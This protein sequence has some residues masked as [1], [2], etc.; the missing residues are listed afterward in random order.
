MG[1]RNLNPRDVEPRNRRMRRAGPFNEDGVYLPPARARNQT[2][3]TPPSSPDS[4]TPVKY[5][6]DTKSPYDPFSGNTRP[7]S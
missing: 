2:Q 7:F 4:G 6:V 5:L 3:F 1:P